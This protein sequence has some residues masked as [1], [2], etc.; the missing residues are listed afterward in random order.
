MIP[1]ALAGLT[2]AL[3]LDRSEAPAAW[4]AACGAVGI[5]LGGQMTY[6]Q[7]VGLSCSA[8]QW[9][10]GLTGLTVKGAVWGLSG[11]AVLGLGFL[12]GRLAGRA[13]A[14]GLLAMVAATAAGWALINHPKLIYF[15]DPVNKPREEVWAGLALGAAAL[16]GVLALHGMARVPMVLAAWGTL[17][18]G[19]GFGLG[20]WLNALGRATGT[21]WDWWKLMEL[22]FGL[23]FGAALGWAAWSVRRDLMDSDEMLP[24]HGGRIWKVLLVAA[25][26]T[27][28]AVAGDELRTR[29]GYTVAAVALLYGA[30]L[31]APTARQVAIT[32]TAAAFFMDLLKAKPSVNT[33]AGWAM[34]V[35]A[36]AAVATAT[37]RWRKAGALFPLL[38]W[39]AVIDGLIKA[40][41]PWPDEVANRLAVQGSLVALGAGAQILARRAEFGTTG[42]GPA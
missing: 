32:A 18:G 27:A 19:V 25:V 36:S 1:G 41:V 20:G 23:L 39:A 22:T 12:H 7:T 6:G 4:L 13:R 9:A 17:G 26:A 8:D 34:V 10:W 24:H 38:L 35:A 16:L 15:S 14:L 30:S 3:L 2:L 40:F 33:A 37:E 29:I 5:G 31:W 21:T 42:A 11:G 28:C